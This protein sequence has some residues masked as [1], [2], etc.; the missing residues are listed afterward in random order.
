ML[1][2]WMLRE[3]HWESREPLFLITAVWFSRPK[4]G[5]CLSSGRLKDKE[6]GQTKVTYVPQ[7]HRTSWILWI[8]WATV[9]RPPWSKH[10]PPQN[11][12]AKQNVF[13]VNCVITLSAIYVSLI[14]HWRRIYLPV[15]QWKMCSN[16]FLF[17]RQNNYFMQLLNLAQRHARRI[18]WPSVLCVVRLPHSLKS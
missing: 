8:L 1:P 18:G 13:V 10:M 12:H 9:P 17:F 2:L 4:S 15:H 7:F 5:S 11:S 3:L 16:S 14:I 6:S